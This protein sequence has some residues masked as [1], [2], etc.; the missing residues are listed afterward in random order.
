MLPS[1]DLLRTSFVTVDVATASRASRAML[2]QRRAQRLAALLRASAPSKVYAPWLAGKPPADVPL[3]SLPAVPKAEL[4][5]RFDEWVTDPAVRLDELQAF[6]RD[7]AR[8]ADPFQGRYTVWESS[9]SCGEPCIFLQDAAAM[10][11]Y[12]AIESL[13]RPVL[14]PL[15]RMLDPF[16]LMARTVFVGATGGHFASTV[17]VERLRRLNPALAHGLRQVS[18]LQPVAGMLAELEAHAPTAVATYPSVALLLAQAQEAGSLAIR[19][20]EIWVGGET[21][22]PS[23]RHRV[24]QAFQCPVLSTYGSSEFL[25]LA[26]ECRHGCLHLNS[27]WAILESVDEKGRAMPAGRQ[28]ATCLLTNLAN[29][30]QPIIR[31]DIGDS[32]TVHEGA[33]ECGSSLPVIEVLGRDEGTLRLGGV[34]N[35]ASA[36]NKGDAGHAGDGGAEARGP[37]DVSAMA[38]STVLETDAGLYDFQLLQQGPTQLLLSTGLDGDDARDALGRA[39]QA[40]Q[41]FLTGQGAP[42]V[43]IDCRSGHASQ[44]GRSGK[45]KRVVRLTA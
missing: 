2:T 36:A 6:V 15:Q 17:S 30:V 9:G 20:H 13:R 24:R 19:P 28:G 38:V 32:V 27:D 10:A 43:H 14:H 41:A 16:G 11:V 31:Y 1:F 3:A 25:S 12:D 7:P 45:V 18:F 42:G 23:V 26:F 29:H 44:R 37:V 5:S 40:L 22:T 4:M 33:C 35:A 8:I 21:L 39:R 34:A